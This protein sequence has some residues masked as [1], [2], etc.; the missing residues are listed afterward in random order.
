MY[1]RLNGAQ[2]MFSGPVVRCHERV[3]SGLG[4]ETPAK[5]VRGDPGEHGLFQ[6]PMSGGSVWQSTFKPL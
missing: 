1:S 2:S 4:G 5:S 6:D 3:I